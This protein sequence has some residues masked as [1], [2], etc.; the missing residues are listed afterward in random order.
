MRVLQE[1]ITTTLSTVVK[2]EYILAVV[3]KISEFC[4][5]SD[6]TFSPT[7]KDIMTKIYYS[8]DYRVKAF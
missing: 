3:Y 7:T 1:K 4:V 8:I 5:I 2:G 6:L